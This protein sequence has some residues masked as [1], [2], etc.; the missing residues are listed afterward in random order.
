MNEHMKEKRIGELKDGEKILGEWLNENREGI[1]EYTNQ[2][3][4][5]NEKYQQGQTKVDK[6][7]LREWMEQW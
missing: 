7:W 4:K 2:V 1:N 5:M 3:W 6:K